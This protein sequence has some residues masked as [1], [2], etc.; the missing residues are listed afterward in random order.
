MEKN[1]AKLYQYTPEI[2]FSFLP[3]MYFLNSITKGEEIEGFIRSLIRDRISASDI[4]QPIHA[5]C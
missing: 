5:I 2:D 3:L 4:H 1:W